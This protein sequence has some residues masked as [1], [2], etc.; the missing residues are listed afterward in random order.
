MII[1]NSV[2]SISAALLLTS[3]ALQ[4]P[5]SAEEATASQAAAAKPVVE[6]VKGKKAAK[7]HRAIASKVTAEAGEST[8]TN[9]NG[10]VGSSDD[11]ALIIGE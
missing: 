6:S 8:K 7:S 9:K 4:A 11:S 10:Y 3:V 5:V 2:L 1:R